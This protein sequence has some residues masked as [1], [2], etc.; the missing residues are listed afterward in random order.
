ME[1]YM[2]ENQK[3][4]EIEKEKKEAA[5]KKKEAGPMTHE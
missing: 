2:T 4:E 3:I 5:R 1:R